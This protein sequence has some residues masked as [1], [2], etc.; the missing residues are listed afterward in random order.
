MLREVFAHE[1]KQADSLESHASPSGKYSLEIT[2]YGSP[3]GWNCSRGVVKS[4]VSVVAVVNRNYGIFPFAWA[5]QHPNGHDYLICGEDYMGQ[6]VIE[7]DTGERRDHVSEGEGFCWASYSVSPNRR[8]VAVHGC[9][10]ACPYQTVIFDITEPLA[11]P[12]R[13]V[14]ELD[15]VSAARDV[16]KFTWNEDNSLEFLYAVEYNPKL[17][18]TA[19]QMTDKERTDH[20]NGVNRFCW[21]IRAVWRYPDHEQ[22]LETHDL[23]S[24]YAEG[25]DDDFASGWENW[26]D[27]AT[28]I[29][30][31]AE[32]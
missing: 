15:A 31:A 18:K 11:L 14:W 13:R 32:E 23:G 24:R 28:E 9:Y 25:F 5:E 21:R 1:N 6:T 19:D 29:G 26:E 3:K 2:E 12:Y 8:F 4:G 7:L 27:T 22:V 17:K 10:W 16:R 30:E 20:Y